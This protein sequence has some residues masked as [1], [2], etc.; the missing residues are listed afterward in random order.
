MAT[1]KKAATKKAKA[2]AKAKKPG[3]A[4]YPS[5]EPKLIQEVGLSLYGRHWQTELADAVGRSPRMVLYW[6]R[7][8]GRRA[9]ADTIVEF[10]HVVDKK[11]ED[12]IDLQ[13]KL[14]KLAKKLGV[15]QE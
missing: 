9:P 15:D 1:K 3:K 11:I 4:L 13:N 10:E 5:L 12:L 14:A 8:P 6:L 7:D 2:K